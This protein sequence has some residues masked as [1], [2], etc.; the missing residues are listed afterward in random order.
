MKQFGC[1][2]EQAQGVDVDIG[3]GVRDYRKAGSRFHP[4]GLYN[5]GRCLEY[6]KGI[7]QNLFRAVKY[8]RLSAELNNDVINNGF[9]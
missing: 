3:L 7:D 9:E 5:C 1:C 8:Y 6:G 2:L 4:D